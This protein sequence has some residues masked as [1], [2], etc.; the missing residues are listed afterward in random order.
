M[1]ATAGRVSHPRH[2]QAESFGRIAYRTRGLGGYDVAFT[3]RR[4]PVQ[5]W[6]SPSTMYFVTDTFVLS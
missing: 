2:L 4:S 3:W 6:P 5:I 1:N